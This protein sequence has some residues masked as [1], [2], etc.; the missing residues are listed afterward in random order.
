[1]SAFA[2]GGR[3]KKKPAQDSIFRHFEP[4]SLIDLGTHRHLSKCHEANRRLDGVNSKR[5]RKRDAA[6][7][8]LIVNI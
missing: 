6:I 4:G 2:G 5:L 7:V 8:L 1:M 3:S